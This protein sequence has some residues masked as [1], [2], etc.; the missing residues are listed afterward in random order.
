[1]FKAAEATALLPP[2]SYR[3]SA[4]L[5]LVRAEQ[6]VSVVEGRQA[7]VDIAMNA[8]RLQ[9]TATGRDGAAPPES[10]LFIVMEDD[11]PRDRREVA[12]SAASQAEF[13][14]P[15]GTYY[16]VARQGDAE[17]RERLEIGSGDVV[18]RTLSAA[19]GRLGLLSD[20]PG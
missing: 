4:E 17:A 15:P 7:P 11:P 9:L 10:A 5:G 16:V 3:V 14:L 12:R 20:R 19:T 6:A 18:R 1:V 13:V 2:G 8:G